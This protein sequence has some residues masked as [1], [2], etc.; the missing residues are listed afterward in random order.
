MENGQ[1]AVEP[2][3]VEIYVGQSKSGIPQPV[4]KLLING[5]SIPFLGDSDFILRVR[6]G[7]PAEIQCSL[8]AERF[9]SAPVLP[10]LI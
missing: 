5:E 6:G 8:Y 2:G 7:G 9:A 1:H 10:L 4:K 3:V